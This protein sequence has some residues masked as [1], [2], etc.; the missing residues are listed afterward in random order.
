MRA[1]TRALFRIAVPKHASADGSAAVHEASASLLRPVPLYRAL[2]R[3]HRRLAPE[4]RA[5]GDDYVKAEFR[6]HQR[7]DNPLQIVS[8]CGQWKIYLD[9]LLADAQGMPGQ[10]LDPTMLDKF[11][12]EQLYQLYELKLAAEEAF[13]PQRAQPHPP[14]PPR[15]EE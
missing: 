15:G 2:L 7:V 1:A 14:K 6:R 11:T 8:F 10:P 4:L 13:D 5:L 12:D 9:T 3:A